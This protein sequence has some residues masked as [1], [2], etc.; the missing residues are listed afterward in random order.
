MGDIK[1]LIMTK[2]IR[3]KGFNTIPIVAITAHAI[4]GFRERYLDAG[5][6]DYLTKPFNREA[7]FQIIEKWAVNMET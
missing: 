7:I 5:M 2:T 4:E 6:D 3:D 1:V